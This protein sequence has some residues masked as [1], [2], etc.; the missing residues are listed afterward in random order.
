MRLSIIITLLA[1]LTISLIGCGTA[2]DP[3][4]ESQGYSSQGA[5]QAADAMTTEAMPTEGSAESVA[6][7]E[8]TG[9]ATDPA[10]TAQEMPMPTE[11]AEMAKPTPGFQSG[12]DCF[13]GLVVKP[14]EECDHKGTML[15]VT[16]DGRVQ[17]GFMS[18]GGDII[19]RG[20][21]I[22]GVS[23]TVVTS[24]NSDGSRTIEELE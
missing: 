15:Q 23:I 4:A 13:V 9:P 18:A 3:V 11:T 7:A 1:I 8:T 16:P 14:G 12:D 5:A 20:A 17:Y 10:A 2:D 21:T 22:N 24:K 6:G 19:I